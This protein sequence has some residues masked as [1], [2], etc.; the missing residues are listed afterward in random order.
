MMNSMLYIFNSDKV[1]E[2]PCCLCGGEV[3]EFTIPNDIWNEVIRLNGR[4]TDREYICIECWFSALRK[5][6]RTNR[7]FA[8]KD[9][10]KYYPTNDAMHE[11]PKADA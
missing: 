10:E 11:M 4:E 8:H 6:L 1:S 3:R 5:I 7:S 2:I 9:I